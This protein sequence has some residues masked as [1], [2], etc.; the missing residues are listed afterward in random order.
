MPL[1]IISAAYT[2]GDLWVSLVFRRGGSEL[3]RV[4]DGRSMI[5]VCYGRGGVG[6]GD[7]V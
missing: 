7:V 6:D 1:V 4:I 2:D 5:E 3:V